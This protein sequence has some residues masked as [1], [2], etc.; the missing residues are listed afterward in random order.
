MV[1]VKKTKE[2]NKLIHGPES[3]YLTPQDNPPPTDAVM[4]SDGYSAINSATKIHRT[5]SSV[6]R[7]ET[8]PPPPPIPPQMNEA[9]LFQA[10]LLGSPA[11]GGGGGGGGGGDTGIHEALYYNDTTVMRTAEEQDMVPSST[12][13]DGQNNLYANC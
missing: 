2:Y 9:D 7:N 10:G 5:G 6:D 3:D 12:S 4:T 1:K 8:T 11:G 13:G